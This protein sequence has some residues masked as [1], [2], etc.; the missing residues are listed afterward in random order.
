VRFRSLGREIEPRT[1]D[2]V[3][4]C[5]AK[6]EGGTLFTVVR[7]NVAPSPSAVDMTVHQLF[8]TRLGFGS[9][10]GTPAVGVLR[11]SVPKDGPIWQYS[12]VSRV[13]TAIELNTRSHRSQVPAPY[14]FASLDGPPFKRLLDPVPS[15]TPPPC[16]PLSPLSSNLPSCLPSAVLVFDRAVTCSG[17]D[18]MGELT[19][20]ACRSDDENCR[21]P[22]FQCSGPSQFWSR[23]PV[24]PSA[25]SRHLEFLQ[26]GIGS[27]LV[28]RCLPADKSSPMIPACAGCHAGDPMKSAFSMTTKCRA[29][30]LAGRLVCSLSRSAITV[31]NAP[32]CPRPDAVVQDC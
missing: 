13:M 31:F 21:A 15:L 1:F 29:E 12:L 17:S 18:L 3:A 14:P 7:A 32:H 24:V 2:Q 28:R 4:S 20:A 26:P 23:F 6:C 9:I 16:F 27:P 11:S 5:I 10:K 22:P 8:L 30:L 19:R 25:L